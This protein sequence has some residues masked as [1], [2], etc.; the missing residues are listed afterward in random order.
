MR[1]EVLLQ[2]TPPRTPSRKSLY[3]SK[4][5]G[6]PL[7]GR[8]PCPSTRCTKGRVLFLFSKVF[9]G[10]AGVTWDESLLQKGTPAYFFYFT[11]LHTIS[12]ATARVASAVRSA[13]MPVRRP[14]PSAQRT[15]SFDQS[16]CLYCV[17]SA[18]SP[19]AFT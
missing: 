19:S 17:V 4:G 16:L 7:N 3:K 13:G 11:I 1:G 9:E 15:A 5:R 6:F 2:R 10:G 18:G 12:A 14:V 8:Q